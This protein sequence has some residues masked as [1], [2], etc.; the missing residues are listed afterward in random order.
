MF[1]V[2]DFLTDDNLKSE[3][4]EI[5]SCIM[6]RSMMLHT[7]ALIELFIQKNA[8]L[9][10]PPEARK[11]LRPI[12]EEIQANGSGIWAWSDKMG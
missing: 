5:F 1:H 9:S 4:A 2:I 11:S 10:T 3:R 8:F 12:Y 6:I 7:L